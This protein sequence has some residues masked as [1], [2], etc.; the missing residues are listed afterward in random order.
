[1]ATRPGPTKKRSMTAGEFAA[2]VPFLKISEERIDA[3]RMALVDQKTLKSVSDIFGWSRQAVGDCVA[4]VWREFQAY[5]ES[6]NT[7]DSERIPDGWSRATLVAPKALI[8]SF[9]KQ[10]AKAVASEKGFKEDDAGK[11]TF[12]VMALSPG[13]KP[14]PL[15]SFINHNDA[16]AWRDELI[17][18][19]PADVA[20]PKD[21]EFGI[22][23]VPLL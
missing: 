1:M 4:V 9:Y 20:I 18:S 8:E 15:R 21:A 13:V 2:V 22:Y 17:D 12:L 23:K 7:K 14:V 11:V 3:A 6:Q 5:Q 10:I 19:H 16:E